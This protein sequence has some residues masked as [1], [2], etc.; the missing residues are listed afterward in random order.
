MFDLLTDKDKVPY[1]WGSL[2]SGPEESVV[3]LSDPSLDVHQ[4]FV[5]ALSPQ[6]FWDFCK[7]YL[8]PGETFWQ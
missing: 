7:F 5:T 4:I 3:S 6:T 8:K 1:G 2:G